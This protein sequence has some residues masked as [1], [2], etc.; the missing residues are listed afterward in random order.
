MNYALTA[1]DSRFFLMLE[2]LLHSQK[3]LIFM[4]SLQIIRSTSKIASKNN[5][6]LGLLQE[7]CFRTLET[8]ILSFWFLPSQI[9][10]THSFTNWS[11][12]FFKSQ[13]RDVSKVLE[14]II[15]VLTISNKF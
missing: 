15:S 3:T 11:N 1:S 8:N 4:A 10:N 7:N 9:Q 14:K 13:M 6:N 5:L 2:N 12:T